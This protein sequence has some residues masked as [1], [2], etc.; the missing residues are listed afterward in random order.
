MLSLS[1][2]PTPFYHFYFRNCSQSTAYIN[3][4]DFSIA[5][6][7]VKA[8]SAE[9]STSSHTGNVAF[10][11]TKHCF[12]LF[13]SS[14]GALFYIIIDIRINTVIEY[15]H[16]FPYICQL[17]KDQRLLSVNNGTLPWQ[18]AIK[19]LKPTYYQRD[20]FPHSFHSKQ[21]MYRESKEHEQ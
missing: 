19:W 15:V 14:W 10:G 18:E 4:V 6:Q 5:F 2:L 13:L 11:Y 3:I 21:G 9:H 1:S 7:T 8:R 17:R 12:R 16:I 20:T